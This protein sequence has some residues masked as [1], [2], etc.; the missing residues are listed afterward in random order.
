[1]KGES[2][3][4]R[5]RV[6][7]KIGSGGTSIVWLAK[8]LVRDQ[9]VAIKRLSH[10]RTSLNDGGMSRELAALIRIH[11]KAGEAKHSNCITLLDFFRANASKERKFN[12]LCLVL[13]LMQANL[14][15]IINTDKK[16]IPINVTKKV[17]RSVLKALRFLHRNKIVH[18]EITTKDVLIKMDPQFNIEKW[19]HLN[20]QLPSVDR[21]YKTIDSKSMQSLPLP[22]PTMNELANDNTEFVLSDFGSATL[23]DEFPVA[24][25]PTPVSLHPP[26]TLLRGWDLSADIWNFG[27]MTYYL[28]TRQS[29]FSRAPTRAQ[30]DSLWPPQFR[31]MEINYALETGQDIPETMEWFFY[32]WSSVGESDLPV[33]S[34]PKEFIRSEIPVV[35]SKVRLGHYLFDGK[36]RLRAFTWPDGWFTEYGRLKRSSFL[37]LLESAQVPISLEERRGAAEFL[38]RCIQLKP[39]ERAT[40]AELLEHD[41]LKEDGDGNRKKERSASNTFWSSFYRFFQR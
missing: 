4:D 22:Q 7:R 33:G 41:W 35:E 6:Q 40:A 5:Y 3:V 32:Q 25:A 15:D 29:L 20:Y 30:L 26:E 16:P 24:N 2:K 21:R 18:R 13:P 1:M 28:L 8:D 31:T 14:D 10:T 34:Y 27:V 17:L 9:W 19:L 39:G 37:E 23:L 11:E 12:S 38:G 36:G